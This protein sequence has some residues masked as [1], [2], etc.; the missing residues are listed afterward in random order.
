MVLGSMFGLYTYYLYRK[1]WE[2]QYLTSE[3]AYKLLNTE[4]IDAGNQ[5]YFKT[6]NPSK[7]IEQT[8]YYRMP[9]KEFNIIYRMKPAFIR[10]VFDHNKEV[11]VPRVKNGVKGYDVFTPFYYYVT[12]RTDHLNVVEDN[13]KTYATPIEERAAIAVHR[14][15]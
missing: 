10:G 12:E 5:F 2:Q 7:A 4:P 11:H 9:E 3:Y 15:W 8:L 6:D 14:G 13:G 1:D